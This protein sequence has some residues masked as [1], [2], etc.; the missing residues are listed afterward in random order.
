MPRDK[1][2]LEC[3][4]CKNRNYFTDKNRRKHPERVEWKKYCPRCDKHQ[5]AQGIEVVMDTRAGRA[6]VRT[7]LVGAGCDRTPRASSSGSATE[8]R[9]VTWP[10]RDELVKA[11]RMI[12]ILSIV[13]GVA[14]RPGW[15]GCSS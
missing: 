15:T 12:V 4:D 7:R 6:A 11:T 2:I 8:L 13:L 14:H 5:A 3:T 9:K 10:T 1:I